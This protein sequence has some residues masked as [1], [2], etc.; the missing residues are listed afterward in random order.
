MRSTTLRLYVLAILTIAIASWWQ[1]PEVKAQAPAPAEGTLYVAGSSIPGQLGIISQNV[2]PPRA[3]PNNS[4]PFD[5]VIASSLGLDHSLV[6]RSD[7][8][9]WASGS[10]QFG[11]LGIDGAISGPGPIHVPG[12]PTI[13][14]VAAGAQFSLALDDAGNVWSWG[15]NSS[16]Q[17]G[18]GSTNSS[19]SAVAV[20][21]VS[22]IVDIAAGADF[23][24]AVDSVGGIWTW[25]NNLTLQLGQPG[26]SRNLP[27]PLPLGP[28]VHMTHVV[29]G[30]RT[31]LALASDGR[32]FG[33][34][35]NDALQIAPSGSYVPLVQIDSNVADMA[36]GD[37]HIVE[38]RRDG[39]VYAR[40]ANAF[41]QLG[42]GS[43]NSS[44]SLQLVPNLSNVIKVGAG[45][46]HSAAVTSRAPKTTA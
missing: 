1:L 5:D 46:A 25:G 4:S 45:R 24:V 2:S 11:Q 23:A 7:G 19:S 32:L 14:D 29:A 12:L 33:W 42:T 10:N 16:G 13:I 18:I 36:A 20:T 26:P 27:A 43:T 17:L 39:H 8:S 9:V 35:A 31:A 37:L 40:G 41:G 3:F 44:S 15:I 38:A 28:T 30:K 6:L 34:G 21:A 22:N